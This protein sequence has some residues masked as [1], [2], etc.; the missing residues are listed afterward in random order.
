LGFYNDNAKTYFEKTIDLALV[1]TYEKFLGYIGNSG[2][3]LDLGCGSGRD[4]KYFK[5][6]GLNVSMLEQSPELAFLASEYVKGDVTVDSYYN[7]TDECKYDGVWAC[8]SL[9]HCPK[10]DLNSVLRKV[11]NSLKISGY[12]FLCFKDGDNEIIDNLGRHF[13]NYTLSALKTE[14]EKIEDIEIMNLWEERKTSSYGGGQLWVNAIVKR[15]A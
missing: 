4:S 11:I 10:S 6:V 14:L 3:I 1:E 12:F 13:S 5:S 2:D 15:I 9:L 7:L 8:A